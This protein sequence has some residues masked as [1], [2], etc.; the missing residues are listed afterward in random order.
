MGIGALMYQAAARY[1]RLAAWLQGLAGRSPTV[2]HA[3]RRVT[4]PARSGFHQ[5]TSGPAAGMRINV[6]GSRPSYV[7]GRAE[8]LLQGFLAE[9][10]KPG[11]VVLDLG[12]NV[13]YF[14]LVA[15]RLAGP[16]GRVVA[17]EPLLSNLAALRAN[18]EANNLAQVEVVVAAVSDRRGTAT[19]LLSGSDQDASLVH[20]ADVGIVVATVTVDQ[21]DL[22]PDVIKIDVEGAEAAAVRGGLRSLAASRPVVVCEIHDNNPTL[23]HEVAGM[24]R[25]LDYR[26]SWLE[27]DSVGAGYWGAHL[28]GLP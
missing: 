1:P 6:A 18:V 10:I 4:G 27:G 24:L 12:A 23:D 26:L 17:V 20:G 5:I 14:T 16:T 11:S 7:L 2:R 19:L 9:H 15:A 21:L 13:G 8:P 22:S 3:M 25:D 28:V